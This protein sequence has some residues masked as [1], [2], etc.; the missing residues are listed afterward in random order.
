[1][2]IVEARTV[3]IQGTKSNKAVLNIPI[4]I[5]EKMGIGKGSE[6]FLQYFDNG[7]LIIEKVKE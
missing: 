5:A 6:V 3:P 4:K 7:Q 1:M 2:K